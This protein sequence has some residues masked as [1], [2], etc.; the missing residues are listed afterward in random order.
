VFKCKTGNRKFLAALAAEIPVVMVIAVFANMG[1][2]SVVLVG[3]A[4]I[5]FLKRR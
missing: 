5:W 1:H 3:E 4:K 2:A